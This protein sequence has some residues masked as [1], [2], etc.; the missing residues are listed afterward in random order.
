[1]CSVGGTKEEIMSFAKASG[2]GTL[3]KGFHKGDA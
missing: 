1:M 3:K 2:G